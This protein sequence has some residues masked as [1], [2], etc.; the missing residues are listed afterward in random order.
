MVTDRAEF[1][2]GGEV[3]TMFQCPQCG[4]PC[5]EDDRFC[6]ECGASLVDVVAPAPT[7]ALAPKPSAPPPP[8]RS[9][10]ASTAPPAA[11]PLSNGIKVAL[12]IGA[13]FVAG[14]VIKLAYDYSQFREQQ[15][16]YDQ[17]EALARGDAVLSGQDQSEDA[18]EEAAG[19]LD[20]E[21]EEP[22]ADSEDLAEDASDAAAE[23]AADAADEVQT[24]QT[25]INAGQWQFN[26]R[27][28][29]VAG[30]QFIEPQTPR[31][32]FPIG[33]TGG[34]ARCIRAS[35][36]QS[37]R[38]IAFPMSAPANCRSDSYR[39]SGGRVS[40]EFTCRIPNVSSPVDAA[41]NGDYTSNSVDVIMRMR[42][43]ASSIAKGSYVD[44]TVEVFYQL[45]GSRTGGC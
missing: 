6:G 39:I 5:A 40:G 41:V 7:P 25:P 22:G 17:A 43:P 1:A 15:D 23:A 33:N 24:A 32:S 37:P 38:G 30:T 29:N 13:V 35:D 14:L 8:E 2:R 34:Y 31:S 28:N 3:A 42:V 36:A 18:L 26:W 11:K 16:A 19:D 12:I 21:N 9:P 20:E 27:M 10:A 4:A 44:E 45:S